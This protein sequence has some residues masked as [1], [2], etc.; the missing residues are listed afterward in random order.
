MGKTSPKHGKSM[1]DK[2]IY[3]KAGVSKSHYIKCKKMIG[4]PHSGTVE[5]RIA[6]VVLKRDNRKGRPN[7]NALKGLK[8]NTEAFD[9]Q[10]RKE[11]AD[12]AKVEQQIHANQEKI[13]EK[14]D[15]LFIEALNAFVLGFLE[16]CKE[17]KLSEKQLI[18]LQDAIGVR[19][20][21]LSEQLKVLRQG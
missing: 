9:L 14:H 10:M 21:T 5:E 3:E 4:F 18:S 13:I 17:C 12:V 6:F 1:T 8:T 7:K 19:L 20:E 2:E 16:D 11:L 15:E